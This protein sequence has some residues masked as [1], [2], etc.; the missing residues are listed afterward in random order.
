VIAVSCCAGKSVEGP[1]RAVV[2]ISNAE[3]NGKI[4]FEQASPKSPV[5][6]RGTVHGLE[7][8]LH[9]MHV[10]EGQ[11]LGADCHQVGPHFNPTGKQ[12]GGPRDANRH[13]GDLGNIKVNLRYCIRS[14]TNLYV[15]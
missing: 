10:H 2:T 4:I 8:G 3:I 11:Q 1:R 9:A 14:L 5:K 15:H 13:V 7:A 12:H 6:I